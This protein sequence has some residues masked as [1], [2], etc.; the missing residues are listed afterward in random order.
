MNRR[1][2]CHLAPPPVA[3]L[4]GNLEP[5]G[6]SDEWGFQGEYLTSWRRADKLLAVERSQKRVLQAIFR[7]KFAQRMR[8]EAK[9][10]GM[11]KECTE[12]LTNH[13]NE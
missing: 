10:F 3:A 8:A 6:E 4:P 11:L 12:S 1:N 5:A 13:W 9:L 2:G 7:A